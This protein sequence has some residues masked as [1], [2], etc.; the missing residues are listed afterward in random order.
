M[1]LIESLLDC[2]FAPAPEPLGTVRG[3]WGKRL[4][5]RGRVIP[6]DLIESPLTA[7]RC[8][9]YR[10]LI[11]EWRRAS[12]PL[13]AFGP[14]MGGLWHPTQIDEAIAEFY[15]DDGTGRA[16]VDPVG[17]MVETA[18]KLHPEPVDMPTFQRA[19][20]VR[21]EPGDW[22]EV[23]GV[24]DEIEDTLDGERGYRDLPTRMALR[25]ESG[26]RILIRLVGKKDPTAT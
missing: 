12:A 21:I 11:E 24:V 20:E 3:P 16:L 6:R 9:Y 8:V 14:G 19:S 4:T 10:F 26:G 1:G 22:V 18:A 13:Q 2:F 17:A 25:A 23:R 5:V 15:V 7:Q